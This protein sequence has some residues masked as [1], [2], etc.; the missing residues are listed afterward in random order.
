MFKELSET[1]LEIMEILWGSEE[2]VTFGALIDYFNTEKNKNWKRQTLSTFLTRLA[3]KGV[4]ETIKQ[5]RQMLYRPTMSKKQFESE[6]ANGLL[7]KLYNS[8][9]KNFMAALYDG[10]HL[11][12][13]QID[14]LKDWLKDK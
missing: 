10:K 5:G 7:D 4:I 8:S 14:D 11:S 12:K 3:E 13:T 6:K 1:E 2:P 9:I